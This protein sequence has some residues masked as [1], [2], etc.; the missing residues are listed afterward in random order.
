MRRVKLA[1][2]PHLLLN[3]DKIITVNPNS[4]EPW[5]AWPMLL[6]SGTPRP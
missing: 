6:Q 5:A 2:D 3:P 4:K 1:L